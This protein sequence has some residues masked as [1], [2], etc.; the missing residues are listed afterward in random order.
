VAKATFDAAM[1]ID[2]QLHQRRAA[3]PAQGSCTSAGQLHQ[4]SCPRTVSGFDALQAWM[5]K[6]RVERVHACLEAT[7]E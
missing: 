2:G 7:G 3:A 5:S 4:R 6:Q 1:L